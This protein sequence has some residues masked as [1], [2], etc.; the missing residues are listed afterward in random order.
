MPLKSYKSLISIEYPEHADC[1][2]FTELM[3]KAYY[4]RNINTKEPIPVFSFIHSNGLPCPTFSDRA[5]CLSLLKDMEE[6]Y[7][8]ELE[9]AQISSLWDFFIVCAKT[10]LC[11]AILDN[12]IGINFFNRLSDMDRSLPSIIWMKFPDSKNNLKGFF[13]GRRGI[14]ETTPG[15]TISWSN[16]DKFD[17]SIRKYVIN[18][19]P[20]REKLDAHGIFQKTINGKK[21]PEGQDINLL[22]EHGCTFLGPY[23]SPEGAIP[24]FSNRTFAERFM[25]INGINYEDDKTGNEYEI[26][27]IKLFD[28]L[29]R[30]TNDNPFFDIGLNPLMHRCDQGWFFKNNGKWM[31]ETVSGIWDISDGNA[32]LKKDLVAPKGN[33]NQQISQLAL[34]VDLQTVVEYPL[35]RLSGPDK[36]P[37]SL[38]DANEIIVEDL[39]KAK[40]PIEL[41]E[42]NFP[43]VDNFLIRGFDKISGDSYSLG[44]YSGD[45]SDLGFLVFPD[46]IAAISFFLN[47]LL[48]RDEE[49]R[50]NG[51]S[52]CWGGGHTG[53]NN[54]S[55][56]QNI[57]YSIVDAFKKLAAAT[58]T[59][60]YK[61]SYCEHFK[62]LV[63]DAFITV[64]I[65]E[66]GYLGDLVFYGLSDGIK[67][68][69][70][71]DEDSEYFKKQIGRIDALRK[72]IGNNRLSNSET[73]VVVK[74]SLGS[75][76]TYLSDDSK[77]I[78]STAI[79]Q[80]QDKGKRVDI[81]YSGI[82]MLVSKVI[83]RELKHRIF[84]PW[85][86][87]ARQEIRKEVLFELKTLKKESELGDV[88]VT[89]LDIL[90]KKRKTD[91]GT[92]RFLF[93]NLREKSYEDIMTD[94]FLNFLKSFE[95]FNWIISEEHTSTIFDIYSKYR[96]G[97][98]HEHLVSYEICKEAIERLVLNSDSQLKKLLKSTK[99]KN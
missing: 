18:E 45:D 15:S 7:E 94:H 89:L 65:E 59:N 95:N 64:Q 17:Q 14:L 97:G 70:T 63:N 32:T 55:R 62:R 88:A 34:S 85:I 28:Y 42:G 72:K 71:L 92:V 43:S 76:Y 27:K 47:D 1:K 10:G 79:S 58:L 37:F 2:K 74:K 39:S 68:E 78:I 86:L 13:F 19:R 77:I 20:L 9:I 96:N 24:V 26:R 98:V 73:E 83:E 3:S 44:T 5:Q 48:P 69:D 8:V 75:H 41:I 52:L 16:Q 11:G 36:T 4:V 49:S 56:E 99:Q 25:E 30:K 31:L 87:R 91:L 23:V 93:K 80:F 60:G 66:I 84:N 35:K 90:E 6:V 57:S 81:D 40:E 22:F 50:I 82:S 29:D 53:S 51:V 54:K 38:D 12:A 67:I 46:I 61:P 21:I 33:L